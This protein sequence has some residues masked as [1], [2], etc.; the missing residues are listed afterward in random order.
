MTHTYQWKGGAVA[1]VAVMLLGLLVTTTADAQTSNQWNRNKKDC[2]YVLKSPE[3]YPL[4][5]IEECVMLWE[6]YRD[7]SGLSPDEKTLYARG[8]SWLFVYGD[9]NQKSLAQGALGRMG[10][11][12]ALIF[13]D[14]TWKD[15][16][17]QVLRDPL[18]GSGDDNVRPL[19]LLP[20]VTP[21]A[22]G[23]G[24]AKKAEKANTAGFK[25]YKKRNYAGA[26]AKF[27]EALRNDPFY[28]KAKFNMAC[29]QSLVGDREGALQTLL[30]LQSWQSG[31]AQAAFQRAR[32]DGDFEPMYGDKRFRMLLGLVRLQILNG[33][34][35][36]GLYH[37]GRIR[38]AF[39]DRNFVVHQYGYDRHIRKRP[40]I[41]YRE[42]YERQ[43]QEAREIV[44]NMRTAVK[45]INWDSPFDLIVVWGD[46][47]VAASEGASGP[48]VQGTGVKRDA[49]NPL[50]KVLDAANQVKDQGQQ[51]KDVSE[52]PPPLPGTP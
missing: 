48:V 9:G 49:S 50:G 39:L 32:S 28:V 15:P 36:P 13:S 46:P 2:E 31:E 20:P 3:R 44:A 1:V 37:V 40:L 26:I 34:S 5:S 29:N 14:G 16:N 51:L 19:E 47:D 21:K 23:K 24:A 8:P 6:Q 38:K 52:T 33:A 25:A 27:E 45:K 10:K 42:G 41:Y 22:A 12:K 7:V 17:L 18:A 35:E 4:P 43:A 11:T 30:E